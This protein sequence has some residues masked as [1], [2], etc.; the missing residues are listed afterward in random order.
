M[1][2]VDAKNLLG[3]WT[4]A[5]VDLTEVTFEGHT[6]NKLEVTD[7]NTCYIYQAP[8]S[9][10]TQV[11]ASG[12]IYIP[13]T[14]TNVDSVRFQVNSVGVS[15]TIIDA[16]ITATDEWV[17]VSDIVDVDSSSTFEFNIYLLA[18]GR[19]YG[20]NVGDY[21]LFR[22]VKAVDAS[23]RVKVNAKNVITNGTFDSGDDWAIDAGSSWSIGSGK[24]TFNGATVGGVYQDIPALI[25]NHFYKISYTITDSNQ[26]S[27]SDELIISNKAYPGEN[28]CIRC[29]NGRHSSYIQARENLDGTFYDK[30]RFYVL[31]NSAV[32]SIDDVE[33]VDVTNK[34][35]V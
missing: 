22:N 26:D 7:S 33:L 16:E 34:F 2:K 17:N 1:I 20:L 21:I 6:V 30:L 25:E 3:D 10:D 32:F 15:G 9:T 35:V 18:G 31:D 27:S 28:T 14:N 5:D 13:S 8:L 19:T 11:R 4:E 24:L 29:D 23:D 12:E